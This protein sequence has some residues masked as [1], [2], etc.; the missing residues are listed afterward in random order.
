MY[1][2]IAGPA[3]RSEQ[4]VAP[5]PATHSLT[6]TLRPHR[7]C[8]VSWC[9]HFKTSLRRL[10][11]SSF[12]SSA[13]GIDSSSSSAHSGFCPLQRWLWILFFCFS[14]FFFL[15]LAALNHQWPRVPWAVTGYDRILFPLTG[16]FSKSLLK[17][18]F[19]IWD[20]YGAHADLDLCFDVWFGSFR[21]WGTFQLVW[22]VW[23][24]SFSCEEFSFGLISVSFR[25]LFFPPPSLSVYMHLCLC[26]SLSVSRSCFLSLSL[27]L[28]LAT[29][30]VDLF[31]CLFKF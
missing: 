11:L 30:A 17:S 31:W 2:T 18:V 15:L 27:C 29:F 23:V 1:N 13:R 10:N 16:L 22:C 3:C 26:V 12:P 8:G 24:W 28:W 14:F 6:H 5:A 9:R 19:L 20:F 7:H 25:S 21:D 4:S